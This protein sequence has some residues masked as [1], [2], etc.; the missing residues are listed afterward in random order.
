VGRSLLGDW[1]SAWHF[2]HLL[3]PSRDHV[4]GGHATHLPLASCSPPAHLIA[5]AAGKSSAAPQRVLSGG[6]VRATV[7]N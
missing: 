1:V 4:L 3:A 2:A 5:A 7:A 6:T